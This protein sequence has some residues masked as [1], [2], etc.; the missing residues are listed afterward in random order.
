MTNLHD[1]PN[2]SASDVRLAELLER[3][4]QLLRRAI[5]HL[6][7]RNIGLDFDDLEQ[8]ARIRLWRALRKETKIDHPA[9][10]LFRLAGSVTVDAMRRAT[11]RRAKLLESLT[12]PSVANEVPAVD[13][14]EIAERRLELRRVHAALATLSADRRTAAGMHLQGFTPEEIAELTGWTSAKAR[15]LV[16]RALAEL[17]E[18]MKKEMP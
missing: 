16:Y 12:T 1:A 10:Y 13:A 4:G 14:V 2:D 11:A 6:C 18:R 8:E 9:S 15:S 7:P 17:R 5:V 3:Y